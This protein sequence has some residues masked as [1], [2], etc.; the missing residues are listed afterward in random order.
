MRRSFLCTLTVPMFVMATGGMSGAADDVLQQ[1]ATLT[2]AYAAQLDALADSCRQQQLSEAA[3]E[4]EAWLPKREP[5]KLTLFVLPPAALPADEASPVPPW[6]KR[7]L[8]LRAQQA[9]AL[10]TLAGRAIDENRPSLALA[11]VTEA[12]RENPDHASGR[13]AL[14][15]M[16]YRDAWHTPF[17][18]RQLGSG[19]VRHEKFG[20]LPKAH[21][22]RYEQGQR[23]YQG[24]WMPVAEE[25]KFRGDVKRGWRV[26]STHYVVTTNHSL[27]EGVRLSRRLER[28]YSVWQQVF[29][30]YAADAKQLKRRLAGQGPRGRAR[31]HNVAYFRTRQEY[32]DALRAAQPRIDITLGIYLDKTKVAYFFAG[33]DQDPGTLYHEATHQLF[34]ETRPVS[35]NVGRGDNF[36]VIEGIACYMESLADHGSYVTLGGA[37]AGRM[38]AARHR[39]LEDQFYVPL[40]ELVQLGMKAL[41]NDTRLPRIYSQSAGLTDFLMHDQQSRYRE[42]LVEYLI[43]V[44][45]G[46]ATTRTLAE[47][48]GVDYPALDRQY[49]ESM[50][51]DVSAAALRSDAPATSAAR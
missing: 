4:L 32:N 29:G 10:F 16:P 31:Q 15:Y 43:A 39:L 44:Y 38:P 42:A 5:D 36:W 18:V 14:G 46:R 49:A 1:R 48:T 3:L 33:D 17:E 35:R 45:T 24:R 6:R 51:R 34:Q 27:A 25:A 2:T 13:R 11:L 26:A 8:A 28:L 37:N 47:L 7:W 22:E 40:V 12:V 30:A 41:Q 23:Y 50:S 20:W 19:K 9:D 21:V